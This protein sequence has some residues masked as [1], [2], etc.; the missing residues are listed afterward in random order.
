MVV[1]NSESLERFAMCLTLDDSALDKPA[2][3]D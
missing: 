1:R 2:R 3:A